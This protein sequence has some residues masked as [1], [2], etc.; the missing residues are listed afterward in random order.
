MP[1]TGRKRERRRYSRSPIGIMEPLLWE[2]EDGHE[3]RSQG[4]L[5]D[6]SAQAQ[7]YGFR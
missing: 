7:K 3:R 6:V 5:I 1:R 2:D 4:R